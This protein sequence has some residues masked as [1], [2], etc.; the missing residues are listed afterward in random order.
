MQGGDG[1]EKEK[2]RKDG[3]KGRVIQKP[4]DRCLHFLM[5][6]YDQSKGPKLFCNPS[7]TPNP[8]H[9]S[10][11][12]NYTTTHAPLFSSTPSF[13]SPSINNKILVRSWPCLFMFWSICAVRKGCCFSHQCEES[14]D[15]EGKGWEKCFVFCYISIGLFPFWQAS[16]Q[17]PT[18][19]NPSV[20]CRG[21]VM[22]CYALGCW[23]N[24]E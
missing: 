7:L 20:V 6:V 21:C 24:N 4:G 1:K 16:K 22:L 5:R 15:E 19:T 14:I 9:L 23:R 8:L 13:F 2:A 3:R 10:L 12:S 17:L 18:I 11:Q